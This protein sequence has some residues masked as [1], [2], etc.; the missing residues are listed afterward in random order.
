LMRY[1][2]RVDRERTI[3]LEIIDMIRRRRTNTVLCKDHL[4]VPDIVAW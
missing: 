1:Y 3:Y 2:G 4:L